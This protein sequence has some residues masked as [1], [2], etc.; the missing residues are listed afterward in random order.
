V[1]GEGSIRTRDIGGSS[2]TSEMADAISRATRN[3][4]EGHAVTP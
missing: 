1:L 3:A 2:S 4:L